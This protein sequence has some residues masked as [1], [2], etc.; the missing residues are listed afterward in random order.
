MRKTHIGAALVAAIVIAPSCG[1]NQNPVAPTPAP[2]PTRPVALRTL[3][4]IGIPETG[5]PAG[6]VVQ[7]T[8]QIRLPDGG[9]EAVFRPTWTSSNADVATVDIQGVLVGLMVGRTEITASHQELDAKADVEVTPAQPNETLWRELAFNYFQCPPTEPACG[10]PLESRMLRVLPVTSPNFA[11]VSH[12]L[13]EEAIANLHEVLALGA[14]QI[15]GE[16]YRGTIQEGDGVRA[17]NWITIEGVTGG[18]YATAGSCRNGSIPEGGTAAATLG[19][20]YGCIM[21]GMHRPEGS[22]TQ[23]ILHEL[24]HAMGFYHTSDHRT[25]MFGAQSREGQRFTAQEQYHTQLAYRH[26][27]GTTYAEIKISTFGPQRHL[28]P[29]QVDPRPIFIVD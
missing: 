6:E 17:E 13:S 27:R 22:S 1:E 20:I 3:E 26:P 10:T 7:L 28:R 19:S 9:I 21:L 12:T 24:G 11:I 23:T 5:L 16:P 25:L 2:E 14:E 18:N 8:A 29:R 15:T 4:I